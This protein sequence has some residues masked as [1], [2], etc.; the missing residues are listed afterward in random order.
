[1]ATLLVASRE[2]LSSIKLVVVDNIRLTYLSFLNIFC[3][4]NFI[5]NFPVH[6]KQ[7]RLPVMFSAICANSVSLSYY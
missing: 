4:E 2:V 3:K 6:S 1:V 5:K 7:S